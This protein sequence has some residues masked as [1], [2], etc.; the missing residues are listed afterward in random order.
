MRLVINQQELK[1]QSHN[2]R[3]QVYLDI[4]F[5]E[6]TPNTEVHTRHLRRG[7]HVTQLESQSLGRFFPESSSTQS[8]QW[9]FPATYLKIYT[10]ASITGT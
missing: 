2:Y 3:A 8:S 4:E 7:L 1:T 6:E 9:V 10:I 5:A